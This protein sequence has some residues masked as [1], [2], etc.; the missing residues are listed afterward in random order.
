M[1]PGQYVNRMEEAYLQHFKVK[2]NQ[3][4]RS[5]LQKGDHPEL[6]T[7]PFLDEKEKEI[8]MS[9]VGSAQ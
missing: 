7:T 6:D 8:Y 2:P 5:P 9:L 1:D 4:H 3:K